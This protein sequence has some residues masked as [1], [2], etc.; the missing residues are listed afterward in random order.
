MRN[1]FLILFSLAFLSA[2]QTSGVNSA[3]KTETPKSVEAQ[4][5]NSPI[6]PLTGLDIDSKVGTVDNM[7]KHFKDDGNKFICLTTQNSTLKSG[8]KIQIVLTE[9]PQKVFPAEVS[10]KLSEKCSRADQIGNSS[11]VS[12]YSLKV[13]KDDEAKIYF[14]IGVINSP[15]QIKIDK[16]LA[17]VDLD[18]DGTDEYFRECYGS[19]SLHLFVWKGKPLVG[20]RIWYSYYDFDYATPPDCKDKDI[21]K[22]EN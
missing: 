10:E 13:S 21:E 6:A 20:K 14:G 22:T 5:I 15:N 16:G 7:D 1:A 9:T 4:T 8:D 11:D 17:H 2:C 12:S 3:P 18:D 19:E